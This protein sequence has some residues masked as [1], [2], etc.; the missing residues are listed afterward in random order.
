MTTLAKPSDF[1]KEYLPGYSGHIPS[2]NERYGA[3]AGQIKREIL[4]DRGVH[5]IKLS[6]R[7]IVNDERAR[8]YSSVYVPRIDKNKKIFG[9]NSRDGE[10]WCCGP[11]HMIRKQQVPGYTGHIK[12]L[13]SENLFSKSYG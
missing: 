4:N 9:N 8:M 11:N 12:G 3:T 5:P 10:N 13:V 1:Y 2:K 6:T 7:N